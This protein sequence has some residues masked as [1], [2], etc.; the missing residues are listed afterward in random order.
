VTESW[1]ERRRLADQRVVMRR[2]ENVAALLLLLAAFT[3]SAAM[4]W[5]LYGLAVVR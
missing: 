1:S 5:L 4:V 2:L 3:A